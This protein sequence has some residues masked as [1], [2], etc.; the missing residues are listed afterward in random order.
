MRDTTLSLR[1][2]GSLHL[3]KSS[4]ASP[5]EA[6]SEIINPFGYIHVASPSLQLIKDGLLFGDFEVCLAQPVSLFI[7][8]KPAF[9]KCVQSVH[10]PSTQKSLIGIQQR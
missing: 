5:L 3:K 10:Q 6:I 2:N 9:F 4:V 7:K 8:Q 1:Q